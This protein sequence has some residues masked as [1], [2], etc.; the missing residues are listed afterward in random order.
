MMA[1]DDNLVYLAQRNMG[2]TFVL[3]HTYF[4]IALIGYHNC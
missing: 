4:G 1:D 2:I 3:W